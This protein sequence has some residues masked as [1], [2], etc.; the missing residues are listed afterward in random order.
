[1]KYLKILHSDF[2]LKQIKFYLILIKLN[3][4]QNQLEP[5]NFKLNLS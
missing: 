5:L 4:L 1:M 2:N 3:L